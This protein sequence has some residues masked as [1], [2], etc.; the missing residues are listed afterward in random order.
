MRKFKSMSIVLTFVLAL[1]LTLAGC[2]GGAKDPSK[3]D[4]GSK[5]VRIGTGGTSG[6]YFAMGGG[7][8]QLLNQKGYNSSAQTTGASVENM[9]L[10]EKAEVEIAFTQNDIADYAMNGKEVFKEPL[11]NSMA[12]AA[13]F[14]E[15][16]QIVVEA[17]SDIKSIN[18]LKGKKIAVGSAD[19]G[20]EVNTRQVLEAAGITY[21]D[22]KAQYLPY[23]E[24]SDHFKDKLIDAMFVTGGV[25]HAAIQ[26]IAS[27]HKVR[28]IPVPA[29]IYNKLKERNPFYIQSTIPKGGYT[30]VNED[31]A[32][33]AVM[34]TLITN[35]DLSEQT[36]YEI[37]KNMFENLEVLKGSHIKWGLVSLSNAKEGITIPFHP[38]ALKYYQEKGIK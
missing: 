30:G 29:D 7:L 18:D 34:S 37:T 24:A 32:T 20:G 4:S 11:K 28:F 26:D 36:V 16:I 6:I 27:L 3:G 9:R 1:S 15:V 5:S 19:S 33:I 14:P 8:A 21:N 35:K 17:D 38:G 10:I 12:V 25:P 31:V 23:G 2:G 13:L 22:I